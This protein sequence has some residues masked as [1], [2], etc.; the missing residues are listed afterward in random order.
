MIIMVF[1]FHLWETFLSFFNLL[2]VLLKGRI[3]E[4]LLHDHSSRKIRGISINTN[5]ACRLIGKKLN[6]RFEICSCLPYYKKLT[7]VLNQRE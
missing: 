1:G 6:S 3:A 2:T 7:R 5:A 4:R